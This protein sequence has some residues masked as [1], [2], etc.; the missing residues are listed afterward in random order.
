LLIESATSDRQYAKTRL[1]ELN[2]ILGEEE[3]H[4]GSSIVMIVTKCEEF[5]NYK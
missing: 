3:K 2:A 1:K 5:Y 4:I